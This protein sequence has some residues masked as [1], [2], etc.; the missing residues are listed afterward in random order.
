MYIVGVFAS[1]AFR[2]LL[3]LS[4]EKCCEKPLLIELL[5]EAGCL[6]TVQVLTPR[7]IR[8]FY[9]FDGILSLGV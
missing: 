2:N 6:S 8:L 9:A 7:L 4:S 1:V 5:W 3:R